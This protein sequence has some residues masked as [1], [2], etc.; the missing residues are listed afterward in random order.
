MNLYHDVCG[1]KIKNVN[2]IDEV[3]EGVTECSEC[4]C[5]L[6][7]D[8]IS[9]IPDGSWV[10]AISTDESFMNAMVELH[11][12]DPI[13]YQLKIQQFKTQIKEQE[14]FEEQQQE[15]KKPHCPTCGSTN[16]GRLVGFAQDGDLILGGTR[17]FFYCNNCGYEW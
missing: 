17:R 5:P 15:S 2:N 16:I 13:E 1:Q 14:A 11:K 12:K 4:L 9:L 3:T 8:R 7:K 10:K 6:Y